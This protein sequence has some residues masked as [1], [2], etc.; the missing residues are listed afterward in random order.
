LRGGGSSRLI[1][2]WELDSFGPMGR[3]CRIG[4]FFWAMIAWDLEGRAGAAL[5]AAVGLSGAGVSFG[6][7]R[8]DTW[9]GVSEGLLNCG[10]GHEISNSKWS[11]TEAAKNRGKGSPRVVTTA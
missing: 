5:G 2:R 7:G 8:S 11:A 10:V 1:S 3:S 9:I 6:A 4:E